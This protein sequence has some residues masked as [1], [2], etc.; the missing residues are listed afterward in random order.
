MVQ[1][2]PDQRRVE[3]TIGGSVKLSGAFLALI[4]RSDHL[5]L[6]MKPFYPPGTGVLHDNTPIQGH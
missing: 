4:N 1:E 5:Y 6:I 2:K 3:I